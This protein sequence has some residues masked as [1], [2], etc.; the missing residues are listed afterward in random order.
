MLVNNA[1]P[2]PYITISP[3]VRS[4]R[5]H[6]SLPPPQ[7]VR[8]QIALPRVIAGFFTA[9]IVV[10]QTRVLPVSGVAVTS[11]S[12]EGG[13]GGGTAPSTPGTSQDLFCA[14]AFGEILTFEAGE[15]ESWI[16][17]TVFLL[18]HFLEVQYDH[19]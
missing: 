16:T 12:P 17:A 15:A 6:P 9:E 14:V 2:V 10:R 18:F 19:M 13:R 8:L 3:R 1:A 11:R 4:P 7:R 5:L